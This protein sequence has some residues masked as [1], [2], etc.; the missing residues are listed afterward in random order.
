MNMAVLQS[1]TD[2]TNIFSKIVK[3]TTKVLFISI[4]WII[5]TRKILIFYSIFH[6]KM[7]D[8]VT[9]ICMDIYRKLEK[10]GVLNIREG[11]QISDILEIC[12]LYNLLWEYVKK[13]L[14]IQA[15]IFLFASSVLKSQNIQFEIIVRNFLLFFPPAPLEYLYMITMV[16]WSCELNTGQLIPSCCVCKLVRGTLGGIGG[17]VTICGGHIVVKF[18]FEID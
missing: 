5:L 6:K 13:Y 8:K 11:L 9:K 1:R 3:I 7:A 17:V 2:D 18:T 4:K 14:S 10:S 15:S 16:T 12:Y